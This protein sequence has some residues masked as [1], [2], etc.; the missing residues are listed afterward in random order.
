M[1]NDLLQRP[2]EDQDQGQ[3]GDIITPSANELEQEFA[4]PAIKESQRNTSDQ[5][6]DDLES[7]YDKPAR[8]DQD[9]N[10]EKASGAPS[11]NSHEPKSSLYNK[12]DTD[13]KSSGNRLVQL[14][15]S[16][17]SGGLTKNRAIGG[18]IGAGVIILFILGGFFLNLFKLEHLLSNIEEP[19]FERYNNL[20]DRRSRSWT[21]AYVKIRMSEPRLRSNNLADLEEPLLF[22]GDGIDTDNP[23][24]D[25]YQTMRTSDFENNMLQRHGVAFVSSVENVNGRYVKRTGQITVN[26]DTKNIN[27]GD[28][29]LNNNNSLSQLN[30][31]LDGEVNLKLFDTDR[32]ARKAMKEAIDSTTLRRQLWKRRTARRNI[33]NLTGTPRWRFFEK[34]RDKADSKKQQ[35]Y[36]RVFDFVL[37]ST[38]DG[39]IINCVFGGA[40]CPKNTDTNNSDNHAGNSYSRNADN[41]PD[42]DNDCSGNECGNRSDNP[43]TGDTDESYDVDE[44]AKATGDDIQSKRTSIKNK[45]AFM[46]DIVGRLVKGSN[47]IGW[48]DMVARFDGLITSGAISK[49]VTLN[50]IKTYSAFYSVYRIAGDQAKT[51]EDMDAEEYGALM[52]SLNGVEFSSSFSQTSNQ[53]GGDGCPAAGQPEGVPEEEFAC[54]GDDKKIYSGTRAGS[55]EDAYKAS[56]GAVLSPVAEAYRKSLGVAVGWVN[57][58][59]EAVTGPIV[60]AALRVSGLDDDIEKLTRW[61]SEELLEFAGGVPPCSA[62]ESG[63]AVHNCLTAGAVATAETSLRYSGGAAS[64]TLAD[65]KTD[66]YVAR[67][68]SHNDAP[69]TERI[70]QFWG[71]L[72]S[73]TYGILAYASTP[74]DVINPARIYTYSQ[75]ANAVSGSELANFVGMKTYDL[76]NSFVQSDPLLIDEVSECT[77]AESKGIEGLT[78]GDVYDYEDFW[79]KVYDQLDNPEVAEEIWNGC[80]HDAEQMAGFAG[81]FSDKDVYSTSIAGTDSVRRTNDV[82][83]AIGGVS[84]DFGKDS[85]DVECPAGAEDLG[86]VQSRYNGGLSDNGRKPEIRLCRLGSI[87]GEGNDT[88]GT[89]TPGG[90][91]VNAHAASAWQALGEAAQADGVNLSANSSFRLADSCGGTG[92]GIRCARPGKSIHQLGGAIDFSDIAN[93]TDVKSG[94]TC[95]NK[96]TSPLESYTW[97]ENNAARFGFKQYAREAWHWDADPNNKLDLRCG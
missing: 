83:P 40:N 97:L 94:A 11:D 48:L 60:Q 66:Y 70:A 4:E 92:D 55:F 17:L 61:A 5:T 53:S 68:R 16:R 20:F 31:A 52:E 69:L 78:M 45:A 50:R 81:T 95:S 93:T 8:R 29:D 36:E 13:K 74:L 54:F 27:L 35:V 9:R 6:T 84:K 19:A 63:G 46:D 2:D 73:S 80:T 72:R 14:A 7:L 44:G 42:N 57:G 38:R 47:I 34:T 12:P 88:S 18:G 49:A 86:T 90:A 85:V 56:I 76:P 33:Q 25:W 1:A 67:D 21:R 23:I 22:R 37:E 15:A 77:N 59:F 62:D 82:S 32:E 58:I 51:G 3:P 10:N 64:T 96:A 79:A 30:A 71:E 43:D 39:S 91:V 28:I 26:G 41:D 24:R 87:G 75:G 65:A 89:E